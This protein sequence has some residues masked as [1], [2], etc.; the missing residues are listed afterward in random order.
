MLHHAFR[1]ELNA[2]HAIASASPRV[3][4]E[5]RARAVSRS[6]PRRRPP[7]SHRVEVAYGVNRHDWTITTLRDG[8][9]LKQRPVFV[10]PA[11]RQLTVTP[12]LSLRLSLR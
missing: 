10:F 5:Q 9:P 11:R 2:C 6:G 7:P 12:Q 1:A 3:S 8:A 4:V